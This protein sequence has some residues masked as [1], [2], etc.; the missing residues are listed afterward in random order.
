ME[1]TGKMTTIDGIYFPDTSYTLKQV[2]NILKH[3]KQKFSIKIT[4]ALEGKR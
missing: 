3:K 4:D 2:Q 1:I